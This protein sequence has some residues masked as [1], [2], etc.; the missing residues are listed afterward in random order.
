M[1]V[2]ET[3]E[4]DDKV[5]AEAIEDRKEPVKKPRSAK[6]TT[7]EEDDV[8]PPETEDGDGGDTETPPTKPEDTKPLT[9]LKPSKKPNPL[10]PDEGMTFEEK[11]LRAY[12]SYDAVYADKFGGIWDKPKEGR[13]KITRK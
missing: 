10:N 7:S 1:K 6:K 4:K 9:P 13:S 12:P 5:A 3:E 11:A 2:K 8:T